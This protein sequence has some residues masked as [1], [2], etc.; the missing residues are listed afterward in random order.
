M[1]NLFLL[2]VSGLILACGSSKPVV[3]TETSARLEASDFLQLKNQAAGDSATWET[4]QAL[5]KHYRA[6]GDL[7]AANEE[8]SRALAKNPLALQ[9]LYDQ[10]EIQLELHH[11]TEAYSLF[12]KLVQTEGGDAYT[13]QIATRVGM[14]F[15]SRQITHGDFNNAAP[16]F[17]PDN[18]SIV[19]QTD[20]DGDMEIYTLDLETNYEQRITTHP[21]R[22]ELPVY[23]KT[24]K[25]IVFTSTRT[26]TSAVPKSE[27]KREIFIYGTEKAAVTQ[28]TQ[29]Q[30]DDWYPRFDPKGVSVVFVSSRD[31]IRDKEFCNL[32]SDIYQLN[33]KSG[34]VS[35]LTDLRTLTGCPV[36]SEDGKTLYFNSKGDDK[37]HLY[38]LNLEQKQ[39]SQ[40]TMHNAND[41]APTVNPKKA[42]I[43]FFTDKNGN[44]DL[45]RLNLATRE[46]QQLTNQTFHEA[47]P[48]Y[49]PDG[50]RLV[51]QAQIK[52]KYQLFELNFDKPLTKPALVKLLEDKIA[53]T[54]HTTA[55]N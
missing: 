9:A 40:L 7:Q 42:E 21:A 36:F 34:E 19:F 30:D 17:A 3:Q 14:P 38:A 37:F 12:L 39:V 13:N 5:A 50:K 54:S 28:I 15:E 10:A 46:L 24:G 4:H 8:L 33:L 23:S 41:A 1:K 48:C 29:N 51:Y 22:D 27:K 53:E 32:W 26:D 49:S 31:D 43:A 18:K 2:I 16:A 47:Y 6:D 20:R 25:M 44:F 55:E 35:R 52:E 45:Y 11:P